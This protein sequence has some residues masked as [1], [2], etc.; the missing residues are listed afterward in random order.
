[1]NIKRFGNASLGLA[2]TVVVRTAMAGE[3]LLH[4]DISARTSRTRNNV[5]DLDTLTSE[6][7]IARAEEDF[8]LNEVIMS[9]GRHQVALRFCVLTKTE[10]E[11]LHYLQTLHL[12]NNSIAAPMIPS[13]L[14]SMF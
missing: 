6:S 10:A 8:D 9:S 11:Q 5:V 12:V 1:M 13:G 2:A 3:V 14:S 7:N 4:G